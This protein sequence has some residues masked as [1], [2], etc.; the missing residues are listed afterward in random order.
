MP[1]PK[2]PTQKEEPMPEGNGPQ[3]AGARDYDNVTTEQEAV[4]QERKPVADGEVNERFYPGEV[5]DAVYLSPEDLEEMGMEGAIPTSLADTDKPGNKVYK[6]IRAP[7]RYQKQEPGRVRRLKMR[8]R[9]VTIPTDANGDPY[10][11][12]EDTIYV[13]QDRA[14]YLASLE[15]H[16]KYCEQF[17]GG[18]IAGNVEATGP[19][20]GATIGNFRTKDRK[21]MEEQYAQSRRALLGM[22]ERWPHEMS[23][24]EIEQKVGPERTLEIERRHARGGRGERPGEYAEYEKRMQEAEK[25]K[26]GNRSFSFPGGPVK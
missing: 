18:V 21:F 10:Y 11:A 14:E 20:S 6:V 1:R 23:L 8:N 17:T 16:N 24:A 19:A 15:R 13:L 26:K 12:T 2:R 22:K 7:S 25:A 9:S 4:S 3:H 5:R